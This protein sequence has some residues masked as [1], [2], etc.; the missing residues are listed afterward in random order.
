MKQ[1]KLV[2]IGAGQTIDELYPI[3]KDLIYLLIETTNIP[4]LTRKI[5]LTKNIDGVFCR[6]NH[7]ICNTKISFPKTLK[8]LINLFNPNFSIRDLEYFY[9]YEKELLFYN[10]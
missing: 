10:F 5:D 3:I 7:P 6:I 8:F 1:K 2:I 9:N 4:I